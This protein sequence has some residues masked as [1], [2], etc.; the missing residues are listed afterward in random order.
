[1]LIGKMTKEKKVIACII[2][3]TYTRKITDKFYREILKLVSAAM[4]ADV[5]ED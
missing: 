2:S 1:M 5:K 4:T 3:A